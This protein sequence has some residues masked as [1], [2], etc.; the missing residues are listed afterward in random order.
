MNEINAAE[1]LRI[2]AV[3]K[4]E[5]QKIVRIK[6]HFHLMV[7]GHSGWML[8]LYAVDL[9]LAG[10]RGRGGEPP[11]GWQGSRYGARGDH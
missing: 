9:T 10:S 2:A 8:L 6:V 11:L 3:S 4:A 5:A 1:R 7:I